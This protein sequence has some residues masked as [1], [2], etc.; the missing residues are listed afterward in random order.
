M[1]SK[2]AANDSLI[3]RAI[4][5]IYVVGLSACSEQ[6]LPVN[7][8]KGLQGDEATV[9][10]IKEW[11]LVGAFPEDTHADWESFFD[12]GHT[13]K[14]SLEYAAFLRGLPA[15]DNDTSDRTRAHSFLY[16]QNAAYQE[17]DELFRTQEAASSYAACI[18]DSE[19]DQDVAFQ[20]VMDDA[21]KVWV[22]GVLRISQYQNDY[23][24]KNKYAYIVH[25]NKGRNDVVVKLFNTATSAWGFSLGVTSALYAKK[26]PTGKNFFSFSTSYLLG[27][28]DTLQ[29]KLKYP[30]VMSPTQHATFSIF[31]AN[32][33]VVLVKNLPLGATWKVPL[34][35]L[36][37]GAYACEL[38]VDEEIL[39]Q[40]IVRGD[41]KKLFKNY[42]SKARAL[43]RTDLERINI[44]VLHKR[45]TYLEE[46]G[47]RNLYDEQIQR[48]IAAVVFELANM[49]NRLQRQ[50]PMMENT[51]GWHLRG[52]RSGIDHGVDHYMLYVPPQV[53]DGRKLPL[54]VIMPYVGLR[55]PFIESYAVANIDRNE[56]LE[57]LSRKYGMAVLWPS[58]RI[59]SQINL[60]PV[61]QASTFEALEAVKRDYAIDDDRIY[62]Y[63][64]CTGGLQALL[65]A[66]RFPSRFAAI[67][68]DG[69]EIGYTRCEHDATN[70][71]FPAD[72]VR[73]NSVLHTAENFRNLPLYLFHSEKDEKA[74]YRLSHRL[75]DS[76]R[77][78]GG[79]V[80][81]DDLNHAIKQTW[82]NMI[83]DNTVIGKA[84]HFYSQHARAV[85]DTISFSTYQL[86][87]NRA[88]WITID[89]LSSSGKS[90]LY[91][92][93]GN[94]RIALQTTNVKACT[95][96]LAGAPA[97]VKGDSV[98]VMWNGVDH[99]Y[100]YPK[101]GKLHLGDARERTAFRKGETTE[102]PANDVF[103][104]RFLI[105]KGTSG[106]A[107][108]NAICQAAVD[109]LVRGWMES[110]SGRCENIVTDKAVR[111]SD[112]KNANLVVVGSAQSNAV[113][114]RMMGK[115]PL[116]VTTSHIRVGD[117]TVE[118]R[119]LS[120]IVLFPNPYNPEKCVLVVGANYDYTAWQQLKGLPLEGWYDYQV[121]NNM[122]SVA[123]GNFNREWR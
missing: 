51:V 39:E 84:F 94:N 83:P 32:H 80:L 7:Y 29:I 41:Y 121:W 58:A 68:T 5:V 122:R 78:A 62:L 46:F 35:M 26:Y 115:I 97:A 15:Y 52:F 67:A 72:W 3:V 89:D 45:F 85:P 87:Y 25:L 70:C 109:T 43:A 99:S 75:T 66:N 79:S 123:A 9:V 16:T 4:F 10:T 101:D 88:Y 28:K 107:R 44:D 8:L 21:V 60:N 82:I 14:D 54:V 56:M 98:R 27:D 92:I 33:A 47:G 40:K 19:S 63:G 30:S 1:G 2:L 38:S 104:S 93:A 95:I 11:R 22:N 100:V 105:V 65:I 77:Q 61:V 118:G 64:S 57:T 48:K 18:I 112:L 36:K 49:A 71:P 6:R 113:L 20:M 59:V 119:T 12:G 114:A 69:P 102:G 55:A 117:R 50:E 108:E 103:A 120:Y 17:F 91:A 81:T 96:D 106:T 116:M 73:A 37:D 23:I 31:D 53:K 76:I 111:E 110:L 24:T 34:T 86:K 74:D 42:G 90:T 13:P